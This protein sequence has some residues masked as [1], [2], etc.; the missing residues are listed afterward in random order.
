MKRSIEI[1]FY[2]TTIANIVAEYLNNDEL[3][4]L[5]AYLDQIGDTLATIA[6][7]GGGEPPQSE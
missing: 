6:A 5:S 7:V 2:L 1:T 4:L 3:T